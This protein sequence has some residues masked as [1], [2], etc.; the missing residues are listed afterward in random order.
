MTA[1]EVGFVDNIMKMDNYIKEIQDTV[2]E[3]FDVDSKYD[4]ETNTLS[5]NECDNKKISKA[6][7]YILS[8]INEDLITIK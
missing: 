1:N 6:K 8:K 3:N 5:I 7:E 4:S 2:K